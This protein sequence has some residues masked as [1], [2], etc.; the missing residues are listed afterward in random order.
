MTVISQC[1]ERKVL[2]VEVEIDTRR[3]NFWSLELEVLKRG[4][5]EQCTVLE[6]LHRFVQNIVYSC[7]SMV[8]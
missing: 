5:F 2:S 1:Q 3:T 7:V 6:P 4:L 8:F